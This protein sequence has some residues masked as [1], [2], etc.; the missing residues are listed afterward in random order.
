MRVEQVMCKDVVTLRAWDPLSSAA[1][2][3]KETG[4]GLVPIVAG[5]G[6]N[7]MVGMVTEREVCVGTY[8][9]RLPPSQIFVG[10]VMLHQ[11]YA[12]TP[13]TMLEDAVRLMERAQVERLPVVDG[14]GQ[15]LGIVSHQ[16]RGSAAVRAGAAGW[17]TWWRR[18]ARIPLA[19]AG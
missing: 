9:H 13:A 2:I 19:R 18:L 15:L 17:R 14:A 16:G 5:D 11:V 1:R 4:C 8:R 6:S 10:S 3:L 7:R 12:C